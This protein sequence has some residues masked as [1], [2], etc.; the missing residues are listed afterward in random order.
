MYMDSYNNYRQ[1]PGMVRTLC[2]EMLANHALPKFSLGSDPQQHH[3]GHYPTNAEF[4]HY[5]DTITT[6]FMD[7]TPIA[8]VGVFYSSSSILSTVAPGGFINHA[9]QIHQFDFWGWTTALEELHVA[10]RP[11]PE[12]KL[13][14]EVLNT[15]KVLI[16]PAADVIEH[17]LVQ[18]V[19]TPWVA[20]GGALLVTA[21]SGER[22]GES[23]WF[24]INP[25]G[26]S[27]QKLTGI[28]TVATAEAQKLTNYENG[29]V[30]YVRDT[31]GNTFYQQEAQRLS[32]L[33]KF[34][35]Y[36]EQIA[37]ADGS[38]F[39]VSGLP[40]TV[41]VNIYRNPSRSQL[42]LDLCN[43][44]L[45]LTSDAI[46]PATSLTIRFP[47]PS[48]LGRSPLSLKT[49]TPGENINA[50]LD[51]T[52]PEH[53]IRINVPHIDHYLSLLLQQEGEGEVP[54]WKKY[55]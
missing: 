31:V 1:N 40:P 14:P 36:L 16:V 41:S 2:Y 15:F 49:F 28:T 51:I 4:F 54:C 8:E 9:N 29:K 18:E 23:G 27:F 24:K 21:N 7:R 55:N 30:L 44:N 48:W 50:S 20:Q 6:E 38:L 47:R 25:Q 35:G 13:T 43:H 45:N 12:W 52:H 34:Q 42:F 46:I 17:T 19:I 39:M 3:L 53:Q 37:P 33:P 32:L 5:V 10:Y 11:L 22:Q 26:L